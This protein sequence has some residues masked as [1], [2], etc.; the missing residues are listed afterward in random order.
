MSHY[1]RQHRL[2]KEQAT[3][4]LA[5]QGASYDA[6]NDHFRKDKAVSES[7]KAKIKQVDAAAAE[8]E[9]PASMTM[10]RGIGTTNPDRY[11]KDLKAGKSKILSDKGYTSV[12]WNKEVAV[13]FSKEK[14]HQLILQFELPKGTKGH[15]MHDQY[16]GEFLMPRGAAFRLKSVEETT[17]DFGRKIYSIKADF[18]G[19][20]RSEA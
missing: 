2:S 9:L 17:D 16:E 18:I 14:E 5:Y 8:G 3:A 1:A 11:L 19:H 20:R 7:I 10:Y 4:V 13:S 6:M 12:T 15:L